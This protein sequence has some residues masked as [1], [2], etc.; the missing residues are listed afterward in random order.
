LPP[1]LEADSG[2]SEVV[3]GV[4]LSLSGPLRLQG[5]QALDG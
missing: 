3:A 4:S 5:E 2:V 1:G